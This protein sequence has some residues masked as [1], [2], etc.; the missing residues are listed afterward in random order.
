MSLTKKKKTQIVLKKKKTQNIL[1][2]GSSLAFTYCSQKNF[3]HKPHIVNKI[4][5]DI[6]I[7]NFNCYLVLTW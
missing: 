5:S 2:I 1:L 4:F 6:M 3:S 7:V